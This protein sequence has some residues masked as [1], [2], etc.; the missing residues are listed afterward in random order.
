MLLIKQLVHEWIL[1]FQLHKNMAA[2]KAIIID[3]EPDGREA[4]K[5]S[6]QK[7]CP[8]INILD[9]CANADEG[10]RSIKAN[11]PHLVFLDVQMPHK[12]GFNLLEELGEFHFEVI[13]VTAH[14]KYAIKAIKF[15]ALDYLLKPVDIDE[16][17]KAIQKARERINQRGHNNHYTSL[18][19]NVNY[20]INQIEKLAIPTFEGILFET[21]HD[22]IFCE[23]DGNYTNL[24]M[25]DGKKIVVSKGLRDFDSMLCESGFFRVHHA[26]LI[27]LKHIKK[28]IKGEGGYVILNGDH[29]IDVSRRKKE[30]FLHALNKI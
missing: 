8:E 30:A 18:L 28:Y 5:L 7:Y 17:Q 3:D 25:L 4:L 14:D 1:A 19:K 26:Y 24:I 12:S 2:I 20:S 15:S 10:F 23:A 9:L 27:N 6:I 11:N 29:H 21:I 22:I 13:F 16:L